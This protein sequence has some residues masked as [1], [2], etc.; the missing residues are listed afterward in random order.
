MEE[1]FC[2]HGTGSCFELFDE[3]LLPDG[4]LDH[5]AWGGEVHHLNDVIAHTLE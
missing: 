1:V 4:T 5:N 3:P 2:T